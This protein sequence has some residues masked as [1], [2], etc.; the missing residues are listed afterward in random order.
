MGAYG[1]LG[2]VGIARDYGVID[3]FMRPAGDELLT[4]RTQG[5]APLLGQP[6][7]DGL[8]DRGEDRVARNHR[9]HVV[10]CDVGPLE[11]VEIVER[12]TIGDERA[13]QFLEVIGGRVLGRM[14]RQADLEEGARFLK[15]PHAIRRRQQ[16]P[17]R[18]GQRFEYDLGCRLRHA[19]ALAVVDGHQTH[20]LQ[21]EQRL[22]HR[23]PADAELLHQIALGRQLVAGRILALLDHRLEAARDLFIEP[24]SP[25][26]AELYWYTYHTSQSK[27]AA[28]RRSRPMLCDRPRVGR[29]SKVEFVGSVDGIEVPQRRG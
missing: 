18:A 27:R 16:M 17:R 25:D 4:G 10:E 8:M 23:R 6:G 20:L 13:L 22:A 3:R 9:Q 2:P 1:A 5:R 26:G 14:A 12:L 19:R 29:R 11:G 21:C 15:V 24:A 7:R 28:G